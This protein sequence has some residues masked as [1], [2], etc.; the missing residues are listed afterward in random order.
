MIKTAHILFISMTMALAFTVSSPA[1]TYHGRLFYAVLVFV[2][3]WAF[4]VLVSGTEKWIKDRRK[5]STSE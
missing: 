1:E 2:G 5:S 3:V 4:L